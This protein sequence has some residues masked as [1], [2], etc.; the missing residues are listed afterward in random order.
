M[1]E[2]SYKT[3]LEGEDNQ[4]NGWQRWKVYVLE[5]IE[6]IEGKV[7]NIEDRR[8][9]CELWCN[10]EITK[11]KVKSSIWGAI[12]GFIVSLVLTLAISLGAGFIT[13]NVD[14]Q[15]HNKKEHIEEKK[16]IRNLEKDVDELKEDINQNNR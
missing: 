3:N 8:R 16:D 9:K 4:G 7:D 14:I 15:E 2:R 6:K 10:Q 11:L 13:K 12:S 1:I 5:T